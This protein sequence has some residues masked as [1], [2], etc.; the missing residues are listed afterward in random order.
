MIP[1]MSQRGDAHAE[2]SKIA[3]A[4]RI[5][6]RLRKRGGTAPSADKMIA[7][8]VASLAGIS[9]SDRDRLTRKL[10][11]NPPSRNN[12]A[13]RDVAVDRYEVQNRVRAVNVGQ[14][15]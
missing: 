6:A 12:P 4:G 5:A 14:A 10:T 9:P 11:E 1:V 3:R 13:E 15:P 7:L 8:A 2:E